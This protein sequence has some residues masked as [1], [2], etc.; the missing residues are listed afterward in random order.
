VSI[1]DGSSF[2]S[3]LEFEVNAGQFDPGVLY[4]A[5]ASRHFVY[6][7]RQGMTLG[8]NQAPQSAAVR[9]ILLNANPHAPVSAEAR[10]SGISNYLIG[11]DPAHW[12]RGVA[13]YARVRYSRVWPGID[14]LFKGRDQSLEYDFIL[15]PGSDPARIRI[16]F[17]NVQSLRLDH[18][19]GL[20][21]QTA[22]GEIRQRPPEIYQVSNRIRRPIAGAYRIVRGREI[23]LDL[24]AYDPSLPLVIDPVVTYA[25]YL[26]GT[27]TAKLNAMASDSTGNLYLTG[28][29]S[30][31]DFP[32]S[33][34]VTRPTGAG[35]YRSESPSPF[36]LAGNGLGPAKVLAL[37]PDPK[38]NAIAYAA[39]SHGVFRTADAGLTWKPGAGVPPDVVTSVAVD[40]ANTSTVYACLTQGLYQS[41]DAG[42]TWK[43][44]LTTPVLSVAAATRPGLVYAGRAAAPILRST[45]GGASWQETG[46]AVTVNALAIDPGNTLTVYAAT[47]RSGVY[48]TNDGGLNWTFSNTGLATGATPVTV[49]AIAIDPRISQ[50]LYAATAT[51]L[52]R[53]GDGASLW[54]PT[55]TAAI[56]SRAVLSLAINPRDANIAYAGTAGAGVFRSGDGGDTWTAAGPANLDVNAIAVDSAGQFVHAGLF[57]GTQGFVTKVS[58]AGALVYSTYLGGTGV[59]EGR[60]IAVDAAGRAYLCGVTSAAD[61][62][63]RN[64]YQ[65]TLSGLRDAFFLRLDA[66]GSSPDYASFLGGRGDDSCEA[67]ALDTSGNLYLAGN[68]YAR[69]AAPSANDFPTSSA[70]YQRSS[71]GGGQDC[72][73]TKFDDTGRRM[74]YSTYLGGSAMDTCIGLAVDRSGYVYLAGNTTSPNFPLLQ[75]SL[76]AT[77]PIPA[78]LQ[79]SAAFVSRLNPDGSDLS[80]SALLGGQR[81]DTEVNGLALDQQG[82]FYLTGYTKATDF[83][84][85]P[86]ALSTV[87]PQRGKTI[88]A[89]VDPNAN[90]LAYSTLLPGSG[91]DAGWKIQADATGN[92]WVLGTASSSQFPVTPDALPHSPT[93]DPTPYAAQLDVAA[94]KLLHATYLGGAA[95][96][97]PSAI[98]LAANGTVFVAGSTLSTEI[99]VDYSVFVQ[100]L[101]FSRTELPPTPAVTAVVNGASFAAGPLSPGEAITI[102]GTNLATDRGVAAVNVNG[103]D[104]PLFYASP[105]QINGQLPFELQPGAATVKVTVNGV[106]SA[107]VAITVAAASPGIFLIGTNR[108]AATNQDGSLN[109]AGNPAAPGSTVTLYFTGIGPLDNPVATGVPA[110][111]AGPLSRATLPV[112]VTIGGQPA[113]LAFAGLTPGSIGLA[114]ANVTV[115]ALPAGDHAVV[116]KI[117]DV[118]SNAPLIAVR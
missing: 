114:Q 47:S 117:G 16:A 15:A 82:R 87:V 3:G 38:N 99:T 105:T 101:D 19:G 116:I 90:R 106:A 108:A 76:G 50:R 73:V 57:Q 115:P 55:G 104:I 40:P 30:S 113:G 93:S 118:A 5:R 35:L 39:T 103:Q 77:I 72:F 111:L 94:S 51:G 12:R 45:D 52:F 34:A 10:T 27:G 63:T 14:L 75:G 83:P 46:A 69:A 44:I 78:A 107:S 28:R 79:F 7:T 59:T 9:M 54:T 25:T 86:N 33:P 53:S 23:A 112:S 97:A 22:H 74:T 48:L 1:R 85:T 21:L 18:D 81:G 92:A 56:G 67:V 32:L 20:I 66:T 61:F 26:A 36:I 102:M 71:P 98:A 4:L 13:H 109:T 88:V 8:L 110:G 95:G 84:L 91:P 65:S 42:A 70:G 89:V 24:E 6:L 60:A 37:A 100:H 41:T 43:N 2:N 64:P 29:V 17:D 68:T 31:P 49:Y 11:N 62:P 80:Y 58:P 96:G